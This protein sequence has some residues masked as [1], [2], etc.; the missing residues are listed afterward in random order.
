MVKRRDCEIGYNCGSSCIEQ[1]DTCRIDE[2]GA[3]SSK[4]LSDFKETFKATKISTTRG[5]IENKS[6]YGLKTKGITSK[7]GDNTVESTFIEQDN[8]LYEAGFRVNGEFARSDSLDDD[9]KMKIA[10]VVLGDMKKLF[11]D[12]PDG[13]MFN[14]RPYYNDG[15]GDKRT[16]VYKKFGFVVDENDTSGKVM[17]AKKEN[18]KIVGHSKQ[19]FNEPDEGEIFNADDKELV[20]LI[21]EVI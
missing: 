5:E 18:G 7:V 4:V 17:Y 1:K 16:S 14:A 9:V 20:Q 15:A 19:E 13:T 12:F 6:L 21:S 10:R 2:V 11:K 3:Q 8:D